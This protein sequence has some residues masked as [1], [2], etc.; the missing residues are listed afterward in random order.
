MAEDVALS[1][2]DILYSVGIRAPK[3][4][5]L[6]ER[7]VL[8]SVQKGD[9]ESYG[10]IVKRYMQSAYYIALGFLH[11]QQDALDVSQDAFIRAFRKIKTFDTRK[12]F[13]PWFYRLMRNLC[14]DHIKRKRR[15]KEIPLDDVQILS[16]EKENEELKK[17]LW[18][19]IEELSLEQREVIILR[20]FQQLSY[21][22]IAELTG[23]P[24]GTVMSS[25]YY[26]KKRLKGIVGKY[27]G[28]E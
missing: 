14:I 21:A 24:L 11:N 12:P 13:F 18:K 20:Y 5:S 9:K 26:A 3:N 6:S 25:L 4:K 19:G 28:Y 2:D 7:Q 8:E 1:K 16:A 17:T 22:E 10:V 27:L 15:A 23:K